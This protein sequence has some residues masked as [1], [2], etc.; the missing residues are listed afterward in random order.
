[1]SEIAEPTSETT[2]ETASRKPGIKVKLRVNCHRH[3]L[4]KSKTQCLRS[5]FYFAWGKY[6]VLLKTT[7]L[8]CRSVGLLRIT[9]LS[10]IT[11]PGALKIILSKYYQNTSLL[12]APP[13]FHL[14]SVSYFMVKMIKEILETLSTIKSEIKEIIFSEYLRKMLEKE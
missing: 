1:M 7:C 10:L 3:F 5:F 9:V 2:S 12:S 11:A 6:S 4:I 13:L 14:F 8:F